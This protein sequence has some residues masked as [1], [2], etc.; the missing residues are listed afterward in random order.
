MHTKIDSVCHVCRRGSNETLLAVCPNCQQRC[1]SEHSVRRS[2]KA[3]CSKECA[4][5][6]FYGG[7]EDELDGRY[8]D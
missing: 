6:F 1:C 2:G 4:E 5:W 7:D 8:D 3:F